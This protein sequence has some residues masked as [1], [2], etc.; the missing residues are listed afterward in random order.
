MRVLQIIEIPRAAQQIDVYYFHVATVLFYFLRVQHRRRDLP[1][2]REQQSIGRDRAEEVLN[3]IIG[4][5]VMPAV[6]EWP[7][8]SERCSRCQDN[9]SRSSHIWPPPRRRA[10]R[11]T[12]NQPPNT[13]PGR[14]HDRNECR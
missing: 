8:R 12:L 14:N 2:L 4:N 9:C 7:V 13:E 3:I 1:I 10:W 11:G 5:E 6:V